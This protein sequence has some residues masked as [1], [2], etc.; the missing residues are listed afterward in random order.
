MDGKLDGTLLANLF[1]GSKSRMIVV[2]VS[3]LRYE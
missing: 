3:S 1:L 2:E